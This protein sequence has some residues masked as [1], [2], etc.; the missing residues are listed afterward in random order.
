MQVPFPIHSLLICI[1]GLLP[2]SLW[3]DLGYSLLQSPLSVTRPSLHLRTRF[4][5]LSALLSS[6]QSITSFTILIRRTLP[7][8]D[9]TLVTSISLSI[10][11]S[12][13]DLHSWRWCC[14]SSSRPLPSRLGYAT[15][16]SSLRFQ[17]LSSCP[18]F[19]TKKLAS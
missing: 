18:S 6:L 8:M 16:V 13:L 7:F 1:T 12:F 9:F 2:S 15:C 11:H 14:P 17:L 3:L 10:Y 4:R 5:M 19:P